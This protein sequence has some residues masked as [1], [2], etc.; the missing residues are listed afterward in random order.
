MLSL[1]VPERALVL[2]ARKD[3]HG[4]VP[5]NA[6]WS[7]ERWYGTRYINEPLELKA[8]LPP[9]QPALAKPDFNEFLPRRF[10]LAC[11]D[12]I[13]PLTDSLRPP[14]L[15][16]SSTPSSLKVWYK[17]DFVYRQPKAALCAALRIPA[18]Y[19]SPRASCLAELACSMSKFSFLDKNLLFPFLLTILF[20]F[21]R[22][23]HSRMNGS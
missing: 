13:R 19:S 18:A 14:V 5:N 3:F 6:T 8:N 9:I 2:V 20:L 11:N 15:L 22:K 10:S 23:I 16:S 17:Q 7:A 1:I 4:T 21:A 12:E